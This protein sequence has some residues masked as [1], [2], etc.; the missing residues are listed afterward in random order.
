MQAIHIQEA[1]PGMLT[2][3]VGGVQT[4][5]NNNQSKNISYYFGTTVSVILILCAAVQS[6]A[7]LWFCCASGNPSVVLM[8]ALLGHHRLLGK[9]EL[10]LPSSV[11]WLSW[12]SWKSV[13][14]EQ[15]FHVCGHWIPEENGRRK[16]PFQGL[17][18]FVP[19]VKERRGGSHCTLL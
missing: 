1:E 13:M 8:R 7:Q 17:Y 12:F 18:C 15:R 16:S 4:D 6:W 14:T 10:P 9:A 2:F 11:L 3:Q 19:R 5:D